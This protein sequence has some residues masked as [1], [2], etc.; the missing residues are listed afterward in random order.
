MGGGLFV[1]KSRPLQ[2]AF[3]SCS[4]MKEQA[5]D[6]LVCLVSTPA[7]SLHVRISFESRQRK[8]VPAHLTDVCLHT[9]TR[10]LVGNSAIV[11]KNNTEIDYL[12]LR[13][14]EDISA[15]TVQH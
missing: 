4:S 2:I 10:A 15:L 12:R 1:M 7:S 5:L 11:L 13:W 6:A 8:K 9:E 3:K 14:D